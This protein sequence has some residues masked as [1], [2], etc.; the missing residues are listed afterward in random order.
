MC[1]L[2]DFL[3][4]GAY[5]TDQCQQLITELASLAEKTGAPAAEEKTEGV[6]QKFM[7][8]DIELETNG[9][10]CRHPE[11]RLT[12]P[13]SRDM[14]LIKQWKSTL[15]ELQ[16]FSRATMYGLMLKPQMD[17]PMIW[18]CRRSRGIPAST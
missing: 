2:N 8:L 13:Q 17:S 15:Q 11:G 18:Q 5:E 4:V 6:I 10:F 1:F 7:A 16:D 14:G 3:F 9:P 12:D